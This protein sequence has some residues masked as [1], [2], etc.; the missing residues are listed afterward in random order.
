MASKQIELVLAAKNRTD[1][2]FNRV[3]KNVTTLEKHARRLK[4]L[5]NVCSGFV[6]GAGVIASFRAVID[7]TIEQEAALKVVEQRLI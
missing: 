3:N 2:A 7:A 4:S 1:K 5:G 6:V